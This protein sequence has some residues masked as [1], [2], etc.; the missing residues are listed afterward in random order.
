MLNWKVVESIVKYLHSVNLNGYILTELTYRVSIWEE[1]R[2]LGLLSEG[3]HVNM[4]TD[5]TLS[6]FNIPVYTSKQTCESRL[7]R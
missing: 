2:M 4:Y 3:S 7:R 5:L 1:E 6:R